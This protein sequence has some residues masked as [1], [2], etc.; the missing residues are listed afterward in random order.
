MDAAVRIA[1]FNPLQAAD[2]VVYHEYCSDD[3]W[4]KETVD[5]PRTGV[6]IRLPD[7]REPWE[8]GGIGNLTNHSPE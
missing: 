7:P 2:A 3:G 8:E 1:S 4:Q 6:K 5:A